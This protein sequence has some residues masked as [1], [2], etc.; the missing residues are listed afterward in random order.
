[1]RQRSRAVRADDRG[2]GARQPAGDPRA[3]RRERR[4]KGRGPDRRRHRRAG[5]ELPPRSPR[6]PAEA[7]LHLRPRLRQPPA[8]RERAAAHLRPH[9]SP[10]GGRPARGP[11]LVLLLL[12]PVQRPARVRLGGDAV[13]LRRDDRV[14]GARARARRRWGCSSMAGASRPAGTTRRWRRTARI[15]SSTRPRARTRPSTARRSTSRTGAAGPA[16]AATTPATR[17][18]VL[19]RGPRSCPRIRGPAREISG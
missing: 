19:S 8:S 6:G 5:R 16:S 14:G 4:G 1:M 17:C 3:A 18:A 10:A 12:Q 9:P 13:D 15:R 7:G 11:V 2:H